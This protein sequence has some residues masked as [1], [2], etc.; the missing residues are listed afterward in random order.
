MSRDVT[1]DFGTAIAQENVAVA[2]FVELDFGS[3]TVRL[4][5]AAYDFAWNGYTWLGAGTIGTINPIEEGAELQ[6]YG[7]G[8]ELTSIPSEYVSVAL[9][10]NYQGRPVKIWIAALDSN[11]QI[12]SD[13]CGPF[14]YRM[15]TMSI[16][17][18][19]T[20]KITLTAESRL[21]IWDTPN[22]RRYTNEDQ[23]KEYAGDKGLE[24]VVQVASKEIVWGRA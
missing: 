8:M 7:V 3:G 12:I 1:T 5:N 18:G 9:G 17:M 23:Q 19:D 24:F 22:I 4:C 11:Y 14:Q 2:I 20:A 13:P 16:D 21:S 15:D 6:M 10:E